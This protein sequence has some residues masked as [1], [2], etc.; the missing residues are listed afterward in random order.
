MQKSVLKFILYMV[1]TSYLYVWHCVFFKLIDN[2][3]QNV[4]ETVFFK[5]TLVPT[6][7]HEQKNFSYYC[8]LMV[9]MG[10]IVFTCLASVWESYMHILCKYEPKVFEIHTYSVT[11]L[12]YSWHSNQLLKIT[13]KTVQLKSQEKFTLTVVMNLTKS[14]R[15]G[16]RHLRNHTAMTWWAS[17]TV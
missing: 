8:F 15:N 5:S 1:F 7:S 9:S 3:K 11:K 4:Q 16:S 10:P 6:Q 12:S 17:D 14:R 2:N 13:F